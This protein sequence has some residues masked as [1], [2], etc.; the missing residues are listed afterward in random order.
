[1]K[2]FLNIALVGIFAVAAFRLLPALKGI[3]SG[4]TLIQNNANAL[5]IVED[6]LKDADPRSEEETP[7]AFEKALETCNLTYSYGEGGYVLHDFNCSIRKGEYIGFHP[8][9]NTSSLRLRTEDLMNKI[10]PAMGHEPRVV[11][12]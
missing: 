7:L 2:K 3:L 11:T 6:G 1:M 4:W 8:C 9:I 5:Q 12:I 10:I